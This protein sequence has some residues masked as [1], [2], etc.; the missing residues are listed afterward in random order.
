[1]GNSIVR[2][3]SKMQQS[4]D[5]GSKTSGLAA[6]VE[7]KFERYVRDCLTYSP[8]LLFKLVAQS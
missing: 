3:V 2:R 5:F 6:V 1:M 7:F 8:C 4:S